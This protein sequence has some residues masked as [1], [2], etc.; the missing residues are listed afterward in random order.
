MSKIYIYVYIIIL[1]VFFRKQNQNQ[2]Q[3]SLHP[4]HKPLFTLLNNRTFT[5]TMNIYQVTSLH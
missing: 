4:S 5:N 2:N 1:L 3:R